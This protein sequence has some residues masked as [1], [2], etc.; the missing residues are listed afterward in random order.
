[1][2]P[3]NDGFARLDERKRLPLGRYTELVTG[4]Y[5]KV[6]RAEDGTL[7]LTPVPE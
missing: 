1:M 2:E 5:Y 7:T 3:R 4:S 6:A